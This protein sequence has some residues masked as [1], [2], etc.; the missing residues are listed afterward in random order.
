MAFTGKYVLESQENYKDFLKA[1]ELE[2]VDGDI[3]KTTV[4]PDGG[5]LKIQF[6]KYLYTAEVVGDKLVE[7]STYNLTLMISKK[8]K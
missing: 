1:L 4:T 7:V 2:T 3:F 5:K 8:I 6:P